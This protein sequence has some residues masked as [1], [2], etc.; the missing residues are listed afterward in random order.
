MKKLKIY[1]LLIFFSTIFQSCTK[2]HKPW[3][4]EGK[5]TI[6]NFDTVYLFKLDITRNKTL[7]DSIPVV[8]HSF[9]FEKTNIDNSLKPYSLNFDKSGKGGTV[10][11]ISNGETLHIDLKEQYKSVYSGTLTSDNYNDYMKFKQDEVDSMMAMVVTFSDPKTTPEK[12]KSIGEKYRKQLKETQNKKINFIKS[13]KSP[14]LN[15]YLLLEEILTSSIIEKEKFQKYANALSTE[16]TETN[17][18]KKINSILTY[19]DAYALNSDGG[20]SDYQTVKKRYDKLDAEN[21]NSIYGKEVFVSLEKLEKLGYGKNAPELIAKT[22][23]GN[24]F[25]LKSITDNIILVDFWAS[26]C[27][28]CRIEN[29]HYKELYDK[30]KD[31]GFTIIGYSLDTDKLKWGK[32]I[33]E[34]KLEWMNISNLKKWKDDTYLDS[35][36]VS[37]VP[38]NIILV[39]GKIAARNLFGPALDEFIY[40]N[41]DR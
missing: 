11:V 26:W 38:A 5:T 7:I 3:K 20:L 32:A 31:Q 36:G 25:N 2:E 29:P 41:I 27:G 1:L 30:F 16:G 19:F 35:Y 18:G 33:K 8:D 23:D 22:V 13:I 14:Q 4:I 12:L 24:D 10:F 21:K 37:A 34:D 15:A 28:P 40:S 6:E 9:V 17:Y 39:N